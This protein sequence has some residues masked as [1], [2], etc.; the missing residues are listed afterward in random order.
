VRLDDPGAVRAEYADERRL[1]SRKA[2]HALGEGPD[3]REMAFAAIAE[4][5][6]ERYLEVGCGE[7]ELAERV[8]QELGSEVVAIDQSERMVELTRARGVDARGGDVQALSFDDEEFDCAAAAWMLYHVPD[9]DRALGELAR[10]LRPN[11]RLV[12]VTNGRDH[13]REIKDLLD[14]EPPAS[15]FDG[16]D[17]D[18]LLSGHFARVEAREAA[19][20]LV[21][22]SRV[23]AQAYVDA[24]VIF[25]GRQLPELEGPLRVRR[26][27]VVLVADKS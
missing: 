10:V 25:A 7:G 23:E 5:A 6:P 18:E 2:A 22:P 16:E 15:T 3:A 1:V 4:A 21:F 14:L 26:E 9:V 17:A 12:A 24:S 11:G 19:G 27:P 8:Q 13:L 20:W